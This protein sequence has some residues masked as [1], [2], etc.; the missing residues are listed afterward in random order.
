MD[1][2]KSYR[3]V[4]DQNIILLFKGQLN[5]DLVTSMI[6]TLGTRLEISE[7]SNATTRK[8]YNIATEV[9]QNIYYQLNEIDLK[10]KI[11]TYDAR[12]AL[13][14]VSARKKFYSIQT[15]NYIPVEKGK[16]LRKRLD[17][18]RDLPMQEL[19]KLYKKLIAE[20]D[21]NS[22]GTLGLGYIDIARKAGDEKLRYRFQEVNDNVDFFTFQIRIPRDS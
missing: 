1:Y 20:E 12:S 3:N 9:I 14:M 18:I 17:E 10:G 11:G 13:I 22:K 5:F 7:D 21:F 19:S 15:G 4:F 8:F 6:S 2:L 16:E